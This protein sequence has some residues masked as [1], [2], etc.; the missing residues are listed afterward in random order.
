MRLFYE[1]KNIIKK[2]KLWSKVKL[3][4]EQKKKSMNTGKIFMIRK[5]HIIGVDYIKAIQGNSMLNIFLR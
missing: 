5:Y 3:I 2:Y 4:K 1:I